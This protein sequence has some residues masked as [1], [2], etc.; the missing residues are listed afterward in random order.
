MFT[1]KQV[2]TDR[3]ASVYLVGFKLH[4]T[5]GEVLSILTQKS[6]SPLNLLFL[7]LMEQRYLNVNSDNKKVK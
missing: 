2:Q 6:K 1:V 5:I 4:D 7:T 3:V